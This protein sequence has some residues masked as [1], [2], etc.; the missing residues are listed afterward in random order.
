MSAIQGQSLAK[1]TTTK[2]G[3]VPKGIN[4]CY[5][6]RCS[7]NSCK[8][9]GCTTLQSSNASNQLLVKISSGRSAPWE[10]TCSQA[11]RI[12]ATLLAFGYVEA[13]CLIVK[14][15]KPFLLD[16]SDPPRLH[17]DGFYKKKVSY[18]PCTDSYEQ[19]KISSKST[20]SLSSDDISNIRQ[21]IFIYIGIDVWNL[22]LCW[23]T[24]SVWI[25]II[26]ASLD[27]LV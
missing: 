9:R 13:H 20:E 26:K 1:D 6:C 11:G 7:T 21:L 23:S 8:S 25:L 24:N 3:R 27:W 22:L 15:T 19:Q 4:F 12:R 10:N 17:M 2:F 5:F 16:P 18:N 14:T